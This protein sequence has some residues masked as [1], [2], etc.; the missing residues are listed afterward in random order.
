MNHPQMHAGLFMLGNPP[1]P[2]KKKKSTW[3]GCDDTVKHVDCFV[4]KTGR[5]ALCA[6]CPR[7]FCAV[8]IVR[9]SPMRR[10]HD[11]GFTCVSLFSAFLWSDIVCWPAAVISA[12]DLRKR[13]ASI[14]IKIVVENGVW[15]RT[16]EI[17]HLPSGCLQRE[18]KN[19]PGVAP[20]VLQPDDATRCMRGTNKG[21]GA[22]NPTTSPSTATSPTLHKHPPS[23]R[24][25][26]CIQIGNSCCISSIS[27]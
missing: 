1:A 20:T 6:D 9:D 14:P 3:M 10:A 21:E 8:C 19:P 15:P 12:F 4:T 24:C 5:A 7:R 23:V 17:W 25:F 2:K 26:G 11:D 22:A 18:F 13:M 27:M 16:P